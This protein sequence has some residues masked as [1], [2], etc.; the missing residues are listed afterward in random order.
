MDKILINPL[1]SP[2]DRPGAEFDYATALGICGAFGLVF[3][4]IVL[5]GRLASFLDFNSFIIVFGGTIG[6]TLVNFPMQDLTRSLVVLQTALW[7]DQSSGLH[8]IQTLID[9][10]SRAR[11]D[12]ILS[13]ENV[14]YS[15]PDPF[16]RKCIQL[17]VDGMPYEEI[18]RT[19]EIELLHLEDRHRRGAQLFQAM[20]AVAPA[21]GLIGT[22]VGLVQM[23][24]HL[25]DPS[26]IGPGMATALLTTF[27]GSLL[28][29]LVFLPLAGKLRARSQ[30]ETNIK[31]MTIEGILCIMKETN[32][33]IIEQ[34][35]M[36]FL[37]PEQR[38]SQFE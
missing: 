25:D 24:E 38:L 37:S 5:G 6:A 28:A 22:L 17:V 23:L 29:Y 19:L 32:P 1:R 13:L 35:L 18:Q 36:S 9:L 21:M 20:G 7:P 31:E 11:S 15:E 10:S 12:G 3:L 27:Y 34:R 8:R 2:D 33:R 26:K 14:A 30:A 16:Y 4:A